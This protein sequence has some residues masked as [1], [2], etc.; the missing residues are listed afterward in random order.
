MTIDG[1]TATDEGGGV[2]NFDTATFINATITG[3]T[4]GGG[5]GIGLAGLAAATTSVTASVVVENDADDNVQ[6]LSGTTN[7]F[8]S[9]GYNIVGGG[10][11]IAAFA[12]SGGVS[13]VEFPLADGWRERVPLHQLA[14]LIVHAIKF[15]G[16][17]AAATDEAARSVR[18]LLA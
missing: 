12:A 15:G 7:S 17:Y 18:R 11:G 8:S 9:G 13:G 16:G 3:N 10:N 4:A 2:L 6:L 1:N 14:P 5:S